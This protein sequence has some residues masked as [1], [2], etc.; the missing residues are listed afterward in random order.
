L[1][2]SNVNL[3]E[4][5]KEQDLE[6]CAVKLPSPLGNI[7]ILPIYRAPSG[8]FSYFLNGSDAIL[9]SLHSINLEFII[10]ADINVNYLADNNRNKKTIKTPCYLLLTPLVQCTFLLESKTIQSLQLTLFLLIL[11][12]VEI[13]S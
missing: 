13:I 2:L 10:C 11:T 8:K 7:C 3:Y 1:K 4:F 5:C 12:E 9:K 6:V